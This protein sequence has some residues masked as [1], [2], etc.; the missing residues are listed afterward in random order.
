MKMNDFI[1]ILTFFFSVKASNM[2]LLDTITEHIAN[3]MSIQVSSFALTQLHT[4]IAYIDIN[5][6]KLKMFPGSPK[7]QLIRLLED[8]CGAAS[9]KS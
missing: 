1:F 6:K 3:T 9:N 5:K 7:V 4:P 2:T 8:L